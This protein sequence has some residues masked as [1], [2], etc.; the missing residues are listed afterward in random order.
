MVMAKSTSK[1]SVPPFKNINCAKQLLMNSQIHIPYNMKRLAISAFHDTTSTYS[2][3]KNN[4][5]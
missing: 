2:Q 5:K 3:I 1:D 4:L